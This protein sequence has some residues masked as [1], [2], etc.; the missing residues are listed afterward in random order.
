MV[1]KM[2][3]DALQHPTVESLTSAL[4]ELARAYNELKAKYD[5]LERE[6]ERLRRRLGNNSQNSSKPPSS[7]QKPTKAVN[8]YNS[9]EK[10]NRKK[11]A[12]KGHTGKSLTKE[13]AQ[14][15]IK[16]GK[17][18][19][20]IATVGAESDSYDTRYVIDLEPRVVVTEIRFFKDSLGIVQIPPHLS[21]PVTYGNGLKSICTLLYAEGVV[22]NDRIQG[23]INS[24]SDNLLSLSAGTIYNFCKTFVPVSR[25]KYDK[26]ISTI[27]SA[28]VVATDATYI[29]IDG[30]QKYIRNFS[31]DEVCLYE[32]QSAKSI[33]CMKKSAILPQYM[34]SLMHDHETALFNFGSE[35][36]ECNAHLFRYLKKNTE[37]SGNSW[38]GK[39]KR[40]LSHA[41][42]K[43]CEAIKEGK[44][45]FDEGFIADIETQYDTILSLGEEQNSKTIGTTAK[46]EECALLKRLRKYKDNFLLFLRDFQIPFTNNVSERDLRKCKNRQKMSGGFRNTAG[47]DM[48]C[49]IMS[50]IETWK[51]EG[52]N[53]LEQIRKAFDQSFALPDSVPVYL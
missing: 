5:K 14:A 30:L 32:P 50:V 2:L 16:S 9:R 31:T 52:K 7:D 4:Q 20:R 49:K 17:V 38:S 6:N 46:K 19:H 22:S 29:S 45:S 10:S 39:L 41:N 53:I 51:R 27:L 15:L 37:D 36:G 48:Y 47:C 25:F 33:A 42:T 40:L 21:S 8:K 35:H 28:P 18:E 23:I 1:E 11:G 3:E 34:G 43:R 44:D 24:M 13:D 26:I 12:Q